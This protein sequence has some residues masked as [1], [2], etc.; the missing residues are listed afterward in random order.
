MVFSTI[1][2]LNYF[3]PVVFL[4]YFLVPF[5]FKNLV[6]LITSLVFYAWGEPMYV[7]IMLEGNPRALS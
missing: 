6:L 4:L 3:L 7:F 2:F 1:E 5:R